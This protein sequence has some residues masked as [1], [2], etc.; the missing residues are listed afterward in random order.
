MEKNIIKKK[1]L[2]DYYCLTPPY[3]KAL[4]KS[5]QTIIKTPENIVRTITLTNMIDVKV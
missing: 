4:K 2:M 3:T 5:F 1:S